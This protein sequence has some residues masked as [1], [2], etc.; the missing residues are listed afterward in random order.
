MRGHRKRGDG[1]SKGSQLLHRVQSM[2][3]LLYASYL[4]FSAAVSELYYLPTIQMK[5]LD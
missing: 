1:N 2:L 3:L 4:I 5:N